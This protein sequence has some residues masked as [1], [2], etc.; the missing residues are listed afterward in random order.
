MVARYCPACPAVLLPQDFY[1]CG[2]HDFQRRCRE[3]QK[4]GAKDWQSTNRE[5]RNATVREYAKRHP[6]KMAE[7]SRRRWER[8][9][10]DPEA[11]ALWR[12]RG[13]QHKRHALG[14]AS[15]RYRVDAGKGKHEPR[16][17]SAPVLAAV[18]ASDLQHATIE[19]R[20]GIG[21]GTLRKAQDRPTMRAS[22][23]VAILDALGLDPCDVGI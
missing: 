18:K 5:R 1:R 21:S 11:L 20:A 23:A 22:T 13:R 7:R 12:D 2:R 9:K 8:T 14:I 19:H 16:V 17:E 4:A 6:D 15:D 10:Q 3:C